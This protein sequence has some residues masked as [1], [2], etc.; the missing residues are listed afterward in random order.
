MAKQMS[1][2]ARWGSACGAPFDAVKFLEQHPQFDWM[3][4]IVKSR[5]SQPWTEFRAGEK[6]D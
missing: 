1:F 2:A 5:P 6:K 4:G 3:A